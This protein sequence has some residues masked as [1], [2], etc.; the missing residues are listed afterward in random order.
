MLHPILH[1]RC[2]DRLRETLFGRFNAR[3]GRHDL[4]VASA[5]ARHVGGGFFGEHGRAGRPQVVEQLW[6]PLDFSPLHGLQPPRTKV[7][8]GCS[9]ASDN[10][11]RPLGTRFAGRLQASPQAWGGGQASLGAAGAM[12]RFWAAECN[13]PADERANRCGH[14][15]QGDEQG[16]FD[17]GPRSD[18]RLGRATSWTAVRQGTPYRLHSKHP[19]AKAIAQQLECT[20]STTVRASRCV[21]DFL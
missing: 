14:A 16:R 1:R 5:S 13:C 17:G 4:N 19:A 11:P 8:V 15:P 7:D 20:D 9:V 3:L 12:L 10:V 2:T 18:F 21:A 6:L